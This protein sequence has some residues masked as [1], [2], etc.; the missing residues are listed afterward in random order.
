MTVTS[1]TANG[2]PGRPCSASSTSCSRS[3]QVSRSAAAA[4]GPQKTDRS[5]SPSGRY[6]LSGTEPNMN[7]S[8]WQPRAGARRGRVR[9]RGGAWRAAVRRPHSARCGAGGAHGARLRRRV[10]HPAR[11]RGARAP[12][13]PRPRARAAPGA[14]PR[15]A[16]AR[17]ARGPRPRQPPPP[18]APPACSGWKARAMRLFTYSC[19]PCRRLLVSKEGQIVLMSASARS[20][21]AGGHSRGAPA[22]GPAPPAMMRA[23]APLPTPSRRP[24]I[25]ELAPAGRALPPA[26]VGGRNGRYDLGASFWGCA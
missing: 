5:M 17:G 23:S 26:P 11:R 4:A 13:P 6:V 9:R 10:R 1:P 8:T 3:A 16:A 2:A 19:T 22:A 18:R 12:S 14:P 15:P 7:A 21:S 25:R 20:H 24:H